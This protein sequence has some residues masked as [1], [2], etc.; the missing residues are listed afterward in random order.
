MA[1]QHEI[2]ILGAGGHGRVLI[3]VLR[4]AG[5]TITAATDADPTR[6]GQTFDGVPIIG[7]DD[8][9]LAKSK[10]KVLLVNGQGN[11]PHR[12]DSGLKLRRELFLRFAERGYQFLNVVSPDAVVSATATLGHGCQI[13]TG[14]IVHPG[15][16]VGDNAVLNSAAS[17]DHDC[18]IGAHSH[19]APG[20]VLC[21]GVKVGAS[22]HV[23][24][25]AVVIP[26][27]KIGANAVVGAGAVIVS[28]VADGATVLGAA[29]RPI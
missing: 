24:A 18:I 12:G 15:T 20:T 5:R 14:V 28:D 1:S 2:I 26:N 7:G 3:D 4:R 8:A 19:I 16:K 11:T 25:G 23:G 6:H 21:G 13:L 27:M 9:V 22:S 29:S 17:V 10:D